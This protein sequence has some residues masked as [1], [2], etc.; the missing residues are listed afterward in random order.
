MS[1]HD[2]PTLI[3]C[4]TGKTGRR[5]ADQLEARGRP[6]RVG[7]RS[8]NPPFDWNDPTTWPA[9]LDGVGSVYVTYCRISLSRAPQR[10]SMP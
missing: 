6:V 10:R 4:G 1:Y 9:A 8:G 5:V 3:T 2:L 7:S